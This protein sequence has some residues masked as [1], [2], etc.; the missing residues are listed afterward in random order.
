MIYTFYSFKGGVGRSMALANVAEI[1]YA[2]GLS[3]LIVDFDL[4]APGLERYFGL[5]ES[6]SEEA[7]S[8]TI[9]KEAILSHRGIVDMLVSYQDISSL[10]AIAPP[11][12]IE[13]GDDEEDQSAT[14][15][16]ADEQQ[17]NVSASSLSER[18]L[19]TFVAEPLENFC[20][21]L[22]ENTHTGGKLRLITAGARDE[23]H[24]EQYT[25]QIQ[26]FNWEDFY[27]N[28]NGE[29]FFEWFRKETQQ[30]A[31]IVLID[32]RTGITEMGGTCT[33]QL[34]DCVLLFV[35]ANQQNLVGNKKIANSLSQ[36]SLIREGRNGREL[37]IIPIP[38]R[39]ENAE[40]E[41]LDGFAQSFQSQLGQF[42]PSHIKFEEDLFT[43]LKIPYVPYYAYSER[44]AVRDKESKVA[45]DL[46]L[47]YER[48]AAVMTELA[49]EGS[50]IKQI[51]QAKGRREISHNL[52]KSGVVQFVGR[53]Q[54]LE[55][56]HKAITQ[57]NLQSLRNIERAKPIAI[58]G[59]AGVGKTELALQYANS[60]YRERKYPGGICWIKVRNN[61]IVQQITQFATDFLK[62]SIPDA[63][64][65]QQVRYCWQNWS[66]GKALI[67]VDDVTDYL[68]IAPFLPT[69]YSQFDIL[70]TTRQ[71]LGSV[72][73]EYTIRELNTNGAVDLI[74]SLL[75]S[76]RIPEQIDRLIAL[77]ERVG[78]LP[79]ALEMMGRFLDRTPD[80]SVDSLLESVEEHT[81][82][83]SVLEDTDEEMTAQLGV[84]KALELS[85]QTLSE[86]EQKLA[87]LI[88]LFAYEPIEWSLIEICAA[89]LNFENLRHLRDRGLIAHSLLSRIGPNTYQ[90][91]RLVR[92]F[93]RLQV[94]SQPDEG[95][96][97]ESAFCRGMVEAAIALSQRDRHE[98]K[99]IE[100]PVTSQTA[101]DKAARNQTPQT[102]VKHLEEMVRH[103]SHHL[104]DQDNIVV[105]RFLAQAYVDQGLPE[106]AEHWRKQVLDITRRSK[107]DDLEAI[108]QSI[109]ELAATYYEQG[110]YD[111]AEPLYQEALEKR[112]ELHG[113]VHPKVA[114]VLDN[115]A[116]LYNTQQKYDEAE[117][118][119]REVLAI[120]RKFQDEAYAR[121][122]NNIATFYDMTDDFE[123]AELHYL[124]SLKINRKVLGSDHPNVA[125]SLYNLAELYRTEEKY[126]ESVALY[127]EAL[128]IR[129]RVLGDHHP[130]S[131][132]TARRLET[133]YQTM[134]RFA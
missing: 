58:V 47:V 59:T 55:E 46:I 118:L 70:L 66:K 44:V 67:V 18:A 80:S 15:L 124:E 60:Q 36:R 117:Q 40:K 110:K 17:E 133:L 31:D 85:W 97:I 71:N 61:N 105:A 29:K 89:H 126:T 79:L 119:F 96:T 88:G 16:A 95:R 48:L 131:Q 128:A 82:A 45:K 2:L 77:C 42:V 54:S 112:K 120:R 99:Q 26:S 19:N 27:L 52:P 100:Q 125:S 86:A 73:N 4:E 51:A 103:Q 63:D 72:V 123:Q 68:E 132:T 130:D 129:T 122:L 3:V 75:E 109:N 24:F 98:D 8:T 121:S 11:Q 92:D 106:K 87:C 23:T 6:A 84:A 114:D 10:L 13:T 91:H 104:N 102:L 74:K 107:Q 69:T 111:D 1:F 35:G 25:Q 94:P 90:L 9:S 28:Q 81:V 38:S 39:I 32:S 56:L 41:S 50:S 5:E 115:L 49:R 78:N 33:H 127:R 14:L 53:E 30:A 21:T 64:P 34:A 116:I 57:S 83:E 37:N 101:I 65:N 76:A 108:A 134:R 113:A 12:G 62:L 7:E 43:D 93:A 22:K 20:I